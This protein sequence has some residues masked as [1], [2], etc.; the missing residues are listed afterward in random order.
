MPVSST[1]GGIV[2]CGGRSTRMGSPKALLPFG[3]ELMLQR[4]VR[5]LS[6]VVS[7]IVVVAAQNQELPLLPGHVRIAR[8]EHEALG[9]LAGLAAG[10]SALRG[11]VD[12]AFVSSCDVPLLKPAFVQRII[13]ALG[14]YD[15]VIPRDGRFH[16]PLA[17]IYRTSLEPCIQELIAA[18][19][20]RPFFLFEKA[21]TLEIDVTDLR[22]VDPELDSLRN[23]NTP[24]EY[25][26][27][28]RIAGLFDVPQDSAH[29]RIER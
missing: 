21:H 25:E 29:D 3:P 13:G 23:T 4:V 15:L 26:D 18:D 20:L 19:R 6:E 28:L 16:H 1:I 8:D 7:P 5:I 11:E 22:S 27:A 2:L 12:A 17:A 24:G 10:L 14:N 9:P